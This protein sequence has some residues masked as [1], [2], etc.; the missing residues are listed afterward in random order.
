MIAKIWLFRCDTVIQ[1]LF[2]H[3]VRILINF[4]QAEAGIIP[5]LVLSFQ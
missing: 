2:L 1:L 4:F 3:M 5:N